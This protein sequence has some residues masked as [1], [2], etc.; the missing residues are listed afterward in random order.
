[1]SAITL[2]QR[3]SWQEVVAIASRNVRLELS[4][5]AKKR[6]DAAHAIVTTVVERAI[7]A[8]G[9]NTGVGALSDRLIP[10]DQQSGLSRNILMSHAVGLGA[11]LGVAE[12]RAI[13]TATVN[14]F[15][16]G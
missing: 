4:A 8:Y 2:D 12:T 1:M 9:V 13:M 11:P 3:L 16:L 6:I 7:R 10:R 5:A 15:A 14:N